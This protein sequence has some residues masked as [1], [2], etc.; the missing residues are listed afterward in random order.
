M[1]PANLTVKDEN[2]D[3]QKKFSMHVSVLIHLTQ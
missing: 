1:A 2:F 3:A